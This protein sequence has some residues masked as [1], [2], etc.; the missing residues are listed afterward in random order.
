M[1]LSPSLTRSTSPCISAS[2]SHCLP[3]T[4]TSVAEFDARERPEDDAADGDE[5]GVDEE[6]RGGLGVLGHQGDT[7][8]LAHA[9]DEA[10][11]RADADD[12]DRDTES[13]TELPEVVL[14]N[15]AV[16]RRPAGDVQARDINVSEHGLV[17]LRP[18]QSAHGSSERRKRERRAL[19]A[20]TRVRTI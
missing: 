10:R 20:E 19:Q 18:V 17:L 15:H 1:P 16:E 2:A 14:A 13:G 5:V 8:T 3:A 11:E 9:A 7:T 12:A 6:E 4:I